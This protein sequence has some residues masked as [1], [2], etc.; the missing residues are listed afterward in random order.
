MK[1]SQAETDLKQNNPAKFEDHHD[2]LDIEKRA[3]EFR[4]QVDEDIKEQKEHTQRCV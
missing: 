3:D 1:E 2:D 4:K